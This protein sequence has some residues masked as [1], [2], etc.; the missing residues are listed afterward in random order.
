MISLNKLQKEG[1]F[2]NLIKDVWETT[3]DSMSNVFPSR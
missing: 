3:T 2:L 1:Y